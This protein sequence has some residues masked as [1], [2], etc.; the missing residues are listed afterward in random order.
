MN[1]RS[2]WVIEYKLQTAMILAGGEEELTA[3]VHQDYFHRIMSEQSEI[4]L[5][6]K[7]VVSEQDV[8]ANCS[9]GHCNMQSPSSASGRELE[10]ELVVSTGLADRAAPLQ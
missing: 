5:H 3:V 2:R 6:T 1:S 7:S 10:L 9:N 4:F 8:A